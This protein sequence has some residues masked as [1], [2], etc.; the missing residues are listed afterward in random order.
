[1]K[2][3]IY[4]PDKLAAVMR[5]TDDVNWSAVAVDAF[6]RELAARGV[7]VPNEE[8]AA[9]GLEREI[10]AELKAMHETLKM[11]RAAHIPTVWPQ[12]WTVT[13]TGTDPKPESVAERASSRIDKRSNRVSSE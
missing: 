12:D 9:R 8:P 1:M 11:S 6:K 4:V 13:C 5:E 7:E 10:L 3:N 2:R